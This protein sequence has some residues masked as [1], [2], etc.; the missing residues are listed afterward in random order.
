MIHQRHKQT[1]RQID[2]MRSQDR[3]LHYSASRGNEQDQRGSDVPSAAAL[4]CRDCPCLRL[5]LSLF[6]RADLNSRSCES[7]GGVGS[8]LGPARRGWADAAGSTELDEPIHLPFYPD[9]SPLTQITL[10]LYSS[11]FS[12]V[13]LMQCWRVSIFLFCLQ[14]THMHFFV[15]NLHVLRLNYRIIGIRHK[16]TGYSACCNSSDFEQT[17]V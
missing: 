8:W 9:S 5:L 17:Y 14:S 3:A 11:L 1:D 13:P 15:Q 10:L 4:S 2:D 12:G 6:L 16:I 7:S